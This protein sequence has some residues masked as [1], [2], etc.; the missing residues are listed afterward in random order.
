MRW[1]V[2]GGTGQLGSEL[3]RVLAAEGEQVYAPGHAELDLADAPRLVR[4]ERPAVVINCAAWTAVDAAEAELERALAVNGHA[5]GEL[6]AA[7]AASGAAFLQ[8]STDYVFD[9]RGRLPYREDEQVSPVNAYGRSKAAGERAA[10]GHGGLVVRTAWLYGA[11]GANF[12]RT[13]I[14]LAG[15]R[16]RVRVVAD[17]W[18]QPTWA[19]ELA[20]RLVLMA[21]KGV[22]PGVYHAT[23]SGM[24]TWYEYAREIFTLLEADPDRVVP[25]GSAEYPTPARR[26]AWSVLGH[27]GW[28][29]VGLAPLRDWRVALR[30]AWPELSSTSHDR[31]DA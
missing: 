11:H 31:G 6:A 25:V 28:R 23:G 14:R 26:P 24:T 13:M 2:T 3:A 18:G 16:E 30:A 12:A 19:A 4:R 17:Q 29:R 22:P 5:V 7:C 8:L 1:L 27:D 15:E 9:G 10:L 21:R 20:E